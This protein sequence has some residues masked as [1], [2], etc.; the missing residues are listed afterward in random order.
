MSRVSR[1]RLGKRRRRFELHGEAF[2][3]VRP[4]N[5]PEHFIDRATGRE[6]A[7]GSWNALLKGFNLP[8]EREHA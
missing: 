2:L 6:H 3:E 1:P 7:G 5:V 8:Q 4:F